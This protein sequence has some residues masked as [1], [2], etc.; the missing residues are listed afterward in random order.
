MLF[1]NK[2]GAIKKLKNVRTC[3]QTGDGGSTTCLQLKYFFF[4]TRKRCR[5]DF[6]IQIIHLEQFESIAIDFEK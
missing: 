5:I 3:P 1:S 4:Q 6:F 2:T